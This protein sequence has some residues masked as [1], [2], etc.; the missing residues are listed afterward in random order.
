MLCLT[1]DKETNTRG[2][3]SSGTTSLISRVCLRK[4]S[5]AMKTVRWN[6]AARLASIP[7]AHADEETCKRE[8]PQSDEKESSNEDYVGDQE[9]GSHECHADDEGEGWRDNHEDDEEK[10]GH[11]GR[12][13]I[14]STARGLQKEVQ[15]GIPF[16]LVRLPWMHYQRG[17]F[18]M[19]DLEVAHKAWS[20]VSNRNAN[21]QNGVNS[22]GAYGLPTT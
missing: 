9:E 10:G 1:H 12:K 6:S 8:N 21:L 16:L 20:N 4:T 2:V 15:H 11:E 14:Q 3:Q 22:A 17:R 19:L 13:G 5:V 18:S 7:L